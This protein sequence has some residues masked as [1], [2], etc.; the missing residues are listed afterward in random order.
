LSNEAIRQEV[1]RVG[2]LLSS[3]AVST[4]TPAVSPAQLTVIASEEIS[5]TR[6]SLHNFPTLKPS[7]RRCA[8]NYSICTQQA[9]SRKLAHRICWRVWTSCGTVDWKT[10]ALQ[11]ATKLYGIEKAE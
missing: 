3:P 1:E 8:L 11:L 2:L 10:Q 9:P 4:V 6:R 7:K 5:G